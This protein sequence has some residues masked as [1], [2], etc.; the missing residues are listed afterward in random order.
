MIATIVIVSLAYLWLLIESDW[1]TIRLSGAWYEVGASCPWHLPDEYVT[2]DMRME[3]IHSW[4]M[5]KVLK[6]RFLMGNESPLCGW[7]YAWQYRNVQL[8]IHMEVKA[9]GVTNTVTLKQ[10][11][12]KLL[13]ELAASMLK[14]NHEQRKELTIQ[15]KAARVTA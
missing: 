9:W 7:G 13:R 5:D 8:D 11:D 6:E 10:A 4:P 15:R 2:E 12:S 14:P 1:L 3:L